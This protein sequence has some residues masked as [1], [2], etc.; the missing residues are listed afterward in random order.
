MIGVLIAIPFIFGG[1][2]TESYNTMIF[3]ALFA[4]LINIGR[5]VIKDLEDVYGDKIEDV[6]SVALK[7]GV[8]PARNLGFLFLLALMLVIPIPILLG[9]YITPIFIGTVLI[10]VAV[11]IFVGYLLFNKL[12]EEIIANSTKSKR[13]LKTC[14]SLGVLAFVLEGVMKIFF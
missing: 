1:F 12:E 7:Y 14:M 9:Y 3:P 11:I 6:Q 5:E 4:F 13:L 8:K 10:I 2:L